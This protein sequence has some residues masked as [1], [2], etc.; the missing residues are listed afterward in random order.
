MR[1]Y[2]AAVLIVFF[3]FGGVSHAD[4]RVERLIRILRTD[5]SY[6]I[7][8]QVAASLGQ[9]RARKGVPVL[10]QALNDRHQTVRGVAAAALG[11]IG[12][13]RA[14]DPLQNL[15]E[16]TRNSFVRRQA[17]RAIKRLAK[18]RR[19]Q[20][21]RRIFVA[22]GRMS[23]HSGKGG[24]S[25]SQA[26]SSAL[27]RAFGSEKGIR[28]GGHRPTQQ[29]LVKQGMR[30]FVVDGSIVSLSQRRKGRDIEISC[31]IKVS[32]ATYPQNSMKAFYSGGASTA[33]PA[34]TFRPEEASDIY[35]ELVEGAAEDAKR[36][37][38]QAYL[39]KQ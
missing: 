25:M 37:I 2:V 18:I 1:K 19:A 34:K 23:N 21:Q 15:A 16:R 26:L 27:I 12:D 4:K 29:D 13:V 32:L 9:L 22:V 38:V 7:R 20:P 28:S 8:I 3:G 10:I 14:L 35:R 11:K 17:K 30:G 24:P 33:V 6:K 39:A 31:S 5:P 36:H